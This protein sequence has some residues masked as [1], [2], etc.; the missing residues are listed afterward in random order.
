LPGSSWDD[1][2]RSAI[3]PGGGVWPRT[4]K[5][6]PLA[7][8][9]RRALGLEPGGAPDGTPA[10]V[11]RAVLRAP[12]DLFW[13]GGIG[14]FVKGATESN[15]EVGDRTND[16]IRID[17]HEL[18]ARVVGEGGN[19]GLTQ[20]GR[21]DYAE[22]GGR[23]NI[24]A[25]DNAAGVDLSDHE[26][27]LKILLGLAETRGDLTR[28]QRDELLAAVVEDV[29]G[30]VLYDN[31]LQAQI[32][33]Q[34]VPGSG[35]RLE[36][37]EDLM[38]RLEAEG[39]LER[40]IEMLPSTEE[41]A[42]RRRSGR[43]LPRPVLAVLLAYAKRSLKAAVVASDLPDEPY[44][45]RELRRYFPGPVVERFGPLLADHPLRREIL[46][47]IVANDVV[48]SQGVTF[49]ARLASETG[50]EPADIARAFWA[51]REVT[52]AVARWADVE[53]LD[54]R[55]DPVVQ[56]DLM[57][58]VDR[59]VES[60]ARWYLTRGAARDLAEVIDSSRAAME[61]LAAVIDATGSPEWQAAREETVRRLMA[62]G[63]P[64]GPAAAH[65]FSAELEHG[66]DIIAVAA[67]TAR[68]ITDVAHA[69]FLLGERLHLDWLEER[70]ADLPTGT[71]WQRWSL[72]AIADDLMLVRR[73][74]AAHALADGE[75]VDVE[76]ALDAYL[77]A[78]AEAY[79]RLG[80]LMGT[81]ALEGVHDQAV[82]TVALRQMRTLVG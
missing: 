33:S 25:I 5:R 21:I 62:A 4:A 45:D 79:E 14:T 9:V 49:V 30:H 28:K 61:E 38:A 16:A 46:A 6:I 17:G 73:E 22:A 57:T 11:L 82:L 47:T 75:G 10:D 29:V 48:N 67:A 43:G 23:I 81:L 13:N 77:G 74:V 32:L 56:N 19:L 53:A 80:R 71:R 42:E 68:P 3:S 72:Q 39:L 65:A 50:A 76:P 69:F 24:D 27:N 7:P 18:R 26:V 20:R 34:E 2:D 1:Y 31:Y 70:V 12:V 58:Q 55:I 54:G 15:A 8:E 60:V 36:A 66:P 51:A 64:P 44:L 41:M 59:L 78:R 63:V 40:A 52:G 37:Y 35:S